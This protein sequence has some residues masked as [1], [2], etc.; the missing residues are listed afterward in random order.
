MDNF[1]SQ[2]QVIQEVLK[3]HKMSSIKKDFN[4]ISSQYRK[5][6]INSKTVVSLENEV[7]GYL[8]GRMGETSVII[9][10]V[11]EK[12]NNVTSFSNHVDSVLDLGSGTGSVLWAIENYIP[13]AN[14]VAV[15]KEKQMIKYSKILSSNL[16]LNI[17]YVHENVLSKKIEELKNA[18]L[19]IESFMLNE[20]TEDDSIKVLNLMG[21]KAA[22][23]IVLVEPGTPKS[24]EKMMKF[25][26]YLLSK[27]LNLVL[28]CPHSGKCGLENDYCNFSVRVP[29]SKL[30]R[31]VKSGALNYEDEK[32]F[33]LIFS[34]EKQAKNYNSTILRRPIYR[35]GCVDLKLCG[36]DSQIKSKTI[37]KSDKQNYKV[38][39][40]YKHGDNIVLE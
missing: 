35:K 12:L 31:Q 3:N 4:N 27:G 17:D 11:L 32:Y 16:S 37:T 21:R 6:N 2:Q 9:D 18:D 8:L 33:Y 36:S 19:V 34:K 40:D 5:E 15:E 14:V 29:R 24:Y 23:Y 1:L 25:R 30:V 28:P 26:E 7:I 10:A 22:K 38:A 13:N 20:L 39:K